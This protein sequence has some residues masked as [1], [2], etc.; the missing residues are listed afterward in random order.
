MH[1]YH[2]EFT[3]F[4][5]SIGAVAFWAFVA[6]VVAM[7]VLRQIARYRENQT[8]I[9]KA[10][11]SNPNLD[12]KLLEQLMRG[13]QQRTSPEALLLGG[14]VLIA[15]GI[16]LGV[17]ALII[18]AGD[19]KGYPMIGVGAIPIT[20]GLGLLVGSRLIVRGRREKD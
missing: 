18:A 10:L 2:P 7:G 17:M 6:V 20:L 12:P 19:P 4:S 1:P 13:E 9:R 15:I 16:G 8:T 14:V 3:P 5:P 11:E